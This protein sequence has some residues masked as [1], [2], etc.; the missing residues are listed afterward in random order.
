MLKIYGRNT[1]SNVQK[2]MWAIGELGLPYERIDIGGAFG[3]NREPAYLAMNPNGLVPTLQDGD[4]VLWE[5]NAIVRHL[6]HRHGAGTIE[7]SDWRARA[8]ADKWMDWQ[9]SIVAPAIFAAFWGLIRTPAEQRD[10]AAISASQAKTAEAMK[11]LDA[12]LSRTRFVADDAFSMGD[13]PL[14]IM[15]Y[16]FRELCPER[17]ALPHLEN[18]YARLQERKAFREHVESIPLT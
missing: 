1:S 12:Q 2:V 16:R 9:L 13:I 10:H 6:A 4:F 3:K 11:I 7:P 17:P 8:R 5:S 18:W 14:G 15:A